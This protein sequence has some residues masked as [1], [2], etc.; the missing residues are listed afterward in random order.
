MY[1]I[2]D[3]KVLKEKRVNKLKE[4][5]KDITIRSSLAVIQVAG[6]AASDT[7]TKNKIKL[8]NEV[9][10]QAK[11]YVLENN[12]QLEE[13]KTEIKHICSNFSAVILQLPLPEH[14]QQHEQ[15]LLDLIPPEKDVDCLS[16]H[17]IGLLHSGRPLHKPCTAQ[18][19]IDVL[20]EYNYNLEGKKALIVGRQN[21]LG[22]PLFRMMTDRNATCTLA[23]SH[24]K[25]LDKM[26][27]GGNYDV[28]VAAI[29][30]AKFLNYINTDFIIDVGIN[31]DCTGKLCGDVNLNT[32]RYTYATTVGGGIG[33]IGQLTVLNLI[34]NSIRSSNDGD[35][36]NDNR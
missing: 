15:E 28:V 22:Y 1:N 8:A 2:I 13:L 12:I 10:L 25:G 27:S 7:Y 5:I 29:G 20:D 23:H 34:E 16:T 9:G 4:Q 14:L 31:R 19:A 18:A 3:C 24:T 11:H 32:C 21:I 26:L 35:D 36:N 17:S 6:D 33:G 30:K